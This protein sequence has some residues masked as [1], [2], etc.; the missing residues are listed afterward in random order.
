[1]PSPRERRMQVSIGN[2]PP[3][4]EDL[5]PRNLRLLDQEMR[6]PRSQDPRQQAI[7]QQE[8]QRLEKFQADAVRQKAQQQFTQ[9]LEQRIN[10]RIGTR[11]DSDPQAQTKFLVETMMKLRQEQSGAQR[12]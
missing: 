12:R 9:R 2:L 7:L 5:D 10:P 4:T 3:Q 1:M 8:R 6:D 11:E